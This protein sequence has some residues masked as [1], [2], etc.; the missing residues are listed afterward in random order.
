MF[1]FWWKFSSL[2]ALQVVKM[3]GVGWGGTLW[4][5]FIV[6][7][8]YFSRNV[9]YFDPYCSSKLGKIYSFDPTFFPCSVSSRRAV[10]SIPIRNMTQY[11]HRSTSIRYRSDIFDVETVW[12]NGLQCVMINVTCLWPIQVNPMNANLPYHSGVMWASWRLKSLATKLF[13]SLCRL[14]S[15]YMARLRIARPRVRGINGWPMNWFPHEGPIAASC[16]DVI[17][18]TGPDILGPFYYHGLT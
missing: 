1:S 12:V 2:T 16:H 4:K 8:L 18:F 17:I 11:T 5:I 7:T 15:K 6:S 13:K 14:T 3:V 10:L 9:E